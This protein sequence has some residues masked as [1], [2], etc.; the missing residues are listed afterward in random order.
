MI[1]DDPYRSS[2][3]HGT[4]P[5]CNELMEGAPLACPAGCGEFVAREAL[6][7]AWHRIL[8]GLEASSWP[9][10]PAPCPMCRRAM[11]VTYR[12]ELR[13]D[14]CDVH[15]VW[16]DAGEQARF[17]ELFLPRAPRSPGAANEELAYLLRVVDYSAT[18]PSGRAVA[19]AI[20]D[21][22]ARVTEIAHHVEGGI[23]VID[24]A[25]G[26]DHLVLRVGGWRSLA[27]ALRER[28]PN[29]TFRDVA[30]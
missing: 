2:A 9:L 26:G 10:D 14:R 27:D 11:H 18:S 12:E 13:F 16:L 24:I 7:D 5:R 22:P 3:L 23:H 8:H 25:A 15:G 6:E 4:C 19:E 20:R 1:E 29:A 28:C 21:A 30:P 17:F